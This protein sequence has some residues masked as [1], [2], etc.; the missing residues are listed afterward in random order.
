MK[1]LPRKHVEIDPFYND[2]PWE[3]VLDDRGKAIGEVYLLPAV[4]LKRGIVRRDKRNE[5]G[6]NQKKPTINFSGINRNDF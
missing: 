4:Y 5:N 6:S 3:I 2:I 1:R